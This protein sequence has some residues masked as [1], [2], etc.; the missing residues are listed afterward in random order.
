MDRKQSKAGG[1]RAGN[2][3]VSVRSHS[4]PQPTQQVAMSM[5][6]AAVGDPVY[7]A[8]VRLTP[9]YIVPLAA[10]AP[11]Y[12]AAAEAGM[13]ERFK[14]PLVRAWSRLAFDGALSREQLANAINNLLKSDRT[15]QIASDI[16]VSPA[17]IEAV[18]GV[19]ADPWTTG[20]GGFH[21]SANAVQVA[22]KVSADSYEFPNW[23]FRAG[24]IEPPMF[25]TV[26]CEV[27]WV[28]TTIRG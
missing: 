25:V 21:E 2:A 23:R 27:A 5:G 20:G 6:P 10:K 26:H 28:R 18:I 12:V 9:R 11:Q 7:V 14:P 15:A 3:R 22:V 24:A 16:A 13:D 8:E 1:G 4:L 19:P 17:K